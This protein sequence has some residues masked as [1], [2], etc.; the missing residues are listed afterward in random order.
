MWPIADRLAT[1]GRVR[2]LAFGNY[3]EASPDVHSLMCGGD[4]GRGSGGSHARA[5]VTRTNTAVRHFGVA[6][7]ERPAREHARA[8]ESLIPGCMSLVTLGLYTRASKA[9]PRTHVTHSTRSST[10][11][12]CTRGI[13]HPLH[14]RD[15][16]PTVRPK[17]YARRTRSTQHTHKHMRCAAGRHA[18]QHEPTRDLSKGRG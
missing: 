8:H 12:L 13:G 16:S 4:G 2:G 7:C 5:S 1:F 9:A 3:S 6:A 14:T 17:L 10:S 18:C 11:G 15:R